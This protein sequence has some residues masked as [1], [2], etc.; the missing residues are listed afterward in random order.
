MVTVLSCISCRQWAF[1][2]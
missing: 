1:N 2:V